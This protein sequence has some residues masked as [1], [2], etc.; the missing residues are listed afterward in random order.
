[1]DILENG[2]VN[3]IKSI[4]KKEYIYIYLVICKKNNNNNFNISIYIISKKNIFK[5]I[6]NRK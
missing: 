3:N 2:K 4:N 6:E 5:I 1:M